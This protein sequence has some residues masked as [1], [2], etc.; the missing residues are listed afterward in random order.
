MQKKPTSEIS[1]TRWRIQWRNILISGL[2]LRET[3]RVLGE[4][5]INAFYLFRRENIHVSFSFKRF[6]LG[7]VPWGGCCQS[8]RW[9]YGFL[10]REARGTGQK[11]EWGPVNNQLNVYLFNTPTSLTE[12][13]CIEG[14]LFSQSINNAKKNPSLPYTY[15]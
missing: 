15:I 5:L 10:F 6:F 3:C 7:T 12:L 8:C 9:L 4:G 13:S 1:C 14:I 11:P 2:E